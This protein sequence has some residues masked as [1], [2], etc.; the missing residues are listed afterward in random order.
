MKELLARQQMLVTVVLIDF[1]KKSTYE[2]DEIFIFDK[3]GTLGNNV[4][5][6]TFNGVTYT[7][8]GQ[9]AGAYGYVKDYSGTSLKFIKGLNSAD[10]SGSDTFRDVPKLNTA[11]RTTATI[12]SIAVASAAVETSNYIATNHANAANNDE[13]ITSLVVGPEVVVVNSTT[14]NNVFSLIGFED[15]ST[16]YYY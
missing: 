1:C 14:Q 9:T 4:D 5:T 13:K 11:N 2:Y 12:S 6:F 16:A 10:W 8:T 15:A 3:V 7:I